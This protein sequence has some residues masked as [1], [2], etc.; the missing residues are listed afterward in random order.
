MRR[1]RQRVLA[2]FGMSPT[3]L[4]LPSLL[5]RQVLQPVRP[6]GNLYHAA[7]VADPVGDGARGHLVPEHLGLPSD[8]HVGGDDRRP[9]LIPR[10]DQLEE[11]VGAAL[12]D[13]QVSQLVDD[14]QLGVGVVLQPLLQYAPGLGVL[15]VVDLP[16]AVH[17]PHLPASLH[18]LDAQRYG[19]MGLADARDADEQRDR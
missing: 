2:R 13:V 12:V 6:S 18:R 3:L 14:E 16:R 7:M 15:E 19:Q 11:Q 9:L 5:G 17:E 8:V 10:A 1:T 4:L